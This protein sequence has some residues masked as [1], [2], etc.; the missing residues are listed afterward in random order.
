MVGKIIS[1]RF[2]ICRNISQIKYYTITIG[3]KY[4]GNLNFKTSYL[5]NQKADNHKLLRAIKIIINYHIIKNHIKIT[6]RAYKT[7]DMPKALKITASFQFKALLP[8]S[9]LFL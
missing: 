3:K 5:S 9:S 4:F 2:H 7:I 6:G 8:P 1:S